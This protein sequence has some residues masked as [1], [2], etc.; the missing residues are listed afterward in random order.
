MKDKSLNSEEWGWW[1]VSI[2]HSNVIV[3]SFYTNRRREHK[4]QVIPNILKSL[5]SELIFDGSVHIAILTTTDLFVDIG[6]YI[7][8]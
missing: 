4:I 5:L 2:E 8:V 3:T 1:V 6:Q 7:D